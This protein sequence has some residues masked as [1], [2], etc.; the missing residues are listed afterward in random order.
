MI[1]KTDK[2]GLLIDDFI[3]LR[4]SSL[5]DIDQRIHS[6]DFPVKRYYLV[7][8]VELSRGEDHLPYEIIIDELKRVF[9]SQNIGRYKDDIVIIYSVP[10]FCM[11]PQIDFGDFRGLLK[12]YVACAG[13][14]NCVSDWTSVNLLFRLAKDSIFMGKTLKIEKDQRIFSH[15]RYMIYH[16]FEMCAQQFPTK[17]GHEDIQYVL[18]PK[19]VTLTIHDNVN[20]DDLM[21]VL[22]SYL[23]HNKNVNETAHDLFMHR[24]TVAG[25]IK[26]ITKILDDDLTSSETIFQ[27]MLSFYL[28]DF[29]HGYLKI[30][31]PISLTQDMT[32]ITPT[33]VV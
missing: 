29:I 26:K 33:D 10:T 27:F 13:I 21:H 22:R 16:I 15:Q 19:I 32:S 4:L 11:E 24:N 23:Q 2:L 3:E 1:G 8:V 31:I 28:L 17:Y 9:P 5:K 14:S 20:S 30:K 18:H 6:L 12:K 7:V 25:K